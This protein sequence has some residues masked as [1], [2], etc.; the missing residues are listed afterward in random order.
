M[1]VSKDF[2]PLIGSSGNQGGVAYEIDQSIRFNDGDSP[3]MNRTPSGAGNRRTWTFSAWIKRGVL[4]TDQWIFSS[5]SDA[6]NFTAI[7]LDGTNHS[8]DNTLRVYGYTG[9][10]LKHWVYGGSQKFRDTSAW[11]HF[12][13]SF[14]ST[15]TSSNDRS[16]I[17]VNGS[18][19][20]DLT[21]NQ[22]PSLNYDT[23]F[24]ATNEHRIGHFNSNYYM[25]GYM[26]EINFLDGYAYGPEYFG[27]T[28][29]SGIW[30]PKEYTGSYGTN[31][32]FIDGRDS[33]DLGDDESGQGNDYTTSGLAAHDQM[34]DTPT[35][36]FCVMNYNTT[37]TNVTLSDGNLHALGSG[38]SISHPSGGTHLIPSSGK[39]YAEIRILNRI[40][41]HEYPTTG[42]YNASVRN[43]STG[44]N[45][46]GTNETGVSGAKDIGFGADERRL[47]NGTNT[48]P[49]GT[50]VD[51]GNIAAIAIDMDNKKIWWGHNQTGSFVWQVSGNPNTGANPA[52][53][54]D[55][56]TTEL[57]FGNGH[58]SSSEVHWN[59]GQ[60]GTFGG[61]VTAQGNA[62]TNG[63]GNFYYPVPTGYMSLCTKNMGS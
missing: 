3:K 54:I 25:D 37:H 43:L 56:N 62:D 44:S 39:W 34:I 51:D 11:Y 63:I 26:A 21:Q 33:S 28:N 61:A 6:N 36:N 20:T 4:S 30:I 19:V 42:V 52:N 55:F 18:R 10:V 24:N 50:G 31:G 60:D 22:Q 38:T 1:P 35:N 15:N 53:T 49:W 23:W 14:D 32:F 40:Q 57:I 8:T 29:S 5:Y 58:Y 48:D 2:L 46:P 16:I 41:P 47:E 9:N 13:V 27:E 17:Y 45:S 12:V 7:Y 59:F